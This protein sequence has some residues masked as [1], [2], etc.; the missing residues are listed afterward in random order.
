VYEL[1]PTTF[2]LKRHVYAESARWEPRLNTWSF[3]NGWSRV[4]RERVDDDYQ[5]FTGSTATFREFDEPPSWFLKEVKT[6]KQMNYLQLRDYIAE[7][8]QSG[9]NTIPLQVQYERKFS[10]PL[11]ALVMAL[12]SVPFAFL[13]GGRGA[14]TGVAVSFVIAIA[15]FAMNYL[16]EQLGNVNL[17][18][19]EAAAWAPLALFTMAA[20]W[21]LTRMRT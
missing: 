3:Q 16:F 13:T 5:D 18:P 21:L 11:F 20:A 8:R 7:L 12:V 19:P 15:Y 17:L 4:I 2:K 6:Y 1:E 14:M 9:F 10:A